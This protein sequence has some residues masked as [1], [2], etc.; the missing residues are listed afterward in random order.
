V[1]SKMG[2]GSTF[3]VELPLGV[4]RKTFTS[5]SAS[6][7]ETSSRPSDTSVKG[8]SRQHHLGLFETKNN[9]VVVARANAMTSLKLQPDGSV[10]RGQLSVFSAF[11]RIALTLA[12]LSCRASPTRLQCHERSRL[13]KH[14]FTVGVHV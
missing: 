13:R 4:G 6:R 3:W 2:E 12:F 9:E 14:P 8:V 1:K 5:A 10:H 11:R 7:H